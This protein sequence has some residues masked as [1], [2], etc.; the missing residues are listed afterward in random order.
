MEV[1]KDISKSE[2]LTI[3]LKKY[4]SSIK[5]K[6]RRTVEGQKRKKGFPTDKK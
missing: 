5:P 1:L 6:V 3:S 4:A 2:F